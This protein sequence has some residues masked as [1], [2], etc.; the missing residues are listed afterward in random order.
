MNNDCVGTS[1]VLGGSGSPFLHIFLSYIFVSRRG[2][3]PW[4]RFLW[5]SISWNGD[6]LWSKWRDIFPSYNSTTNM[7]VRRRKTRLVSLTSKHTVCTHGLSRYWSNFTIWF[8]N[9]FFIGPDHCCLIAL[10]ITMA[11][12]HS[13]LLLRLDWCDRGVWRFMQ[14][15]KATQHPI[16]LFYRILPNRTCCWN[17]AHISKLDFLSDPSPI[18]ALTWLFG[19][20][21]L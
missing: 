8:Q 4:G 10:S 13:P 5:S 17:L 14:P 20:F 9:A 3:S 15:L 11:V 12:N 2:G 16:A 19:G 18:I 21:C 6:R 1:C 7:S